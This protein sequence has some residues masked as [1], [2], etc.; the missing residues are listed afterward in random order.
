MAVVL[1][2][3]ADDVLY[4]Q[5]L[6]EEGLTE[7]DILVNDYLNKLSEIGTKKQLGEW[8]NDLGKSY[9]YT[10]KEEIEKWYQTLVQQHGKRKVSEES[11]L[12]RWPLFIANNN[13]SDRLPQQGKMNDCQICL[14]WVT[15]IILYVPN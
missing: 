10:N 2:F 4:R 11:C 8:R 7:T 15:S 3:H 6:E 1:C 13:L 9:D 14:R 12:F 5:L